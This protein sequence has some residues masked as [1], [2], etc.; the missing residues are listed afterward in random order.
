M[1]SEPMPEPVSREDHVRR[2]LSQ[3]I[4]RLGGLLGHVILNLEGQAIFDLIEEVRGATKQLREHPSLDSARAL[5]DR[6]KRLPLTTLRKLNRAFSIYFD[7]INLAEQQARLRSLRL[8]SLVA[9]APPS[10]GIESALRQLQEEKVGP[11]EL[12]R[13]LQQLRIVPV[14]TAHPSEARRR[15]ILEKLDTISADLARLDTEEL[16]ARDRLDI[17]DHLQAEIETLWLTNLVRT[18]RPSVLDEVRHGTAIIGPLMQV[19]PRLYKSLARSLGEVYPGLPRPPAILDF[20]SWIGGDRDG[21]PFVTADCTLE[22]V[23]ILQTRIIDSYLPR[24]EELTRI[25]SLANNLTT[26]GPAFQRVLDRCQ[27]LVPEALE[28]MQHEPYRAVCRAMAAR[29]QATREWVRQLRLYWSAD[30]REPPAIVYRARAEFLHDLRAMQEDLRLAGVRRTANGELEDLI[31]LVEVFGLHMFSL[32][33]RQHAARHTQAVDEILRAAEVCP[34]YHSLTPEARFALLARELESPRP[35]VPTHLSFSP[36]SCEVIQTFRTVSALLEQQ[37]GESIENYVISGATEPSDVLEVLLLAKE[38]RLFRPAEAISRIHVVPL[39]EALEPLRS[40]PQIIGQLLDLPVY[41]RHLELRG[42]LQEVMIGYS[43]SNKESGFLQS[44]WALYCAQRELAE[45]QRRSGVAIRIFHGRGGAIG[46]GGGPANRA[47]LAQPSGLADGCMRFTE[48]GEVIADRYGCPGIAERHLEQILN[49]VLRNSSAIETPPPLPE[50]EQLVGTL[51]ELARQHYRTLVYETPEFLTYFEQ[52]TPISEIGKL[53]IASRPAKRGNNRTAGIDE[54]RAIPW[55]FS[56]MQSRHTLP[57]WYGLGSA[58]RQHL[59]ETPSARATLRE[60]YARWP[61][62]RTLI[63]NAQMILAKADL[64]IARL[65]ADLVSSP[66]VGNQIH[67][68]IADEYATTVQAVLEMTGQRELLDTMP[69]LQRSI[70]QRNPYVD[71]LSFVQLVLLEQ[72]RNGAEPQ[73]EYLTGVL[74]SI[75]GIASGLKNTG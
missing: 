37:C 31:R 28:R 44:N 9:E 62:W 4:R 13:L 22:A 18:E 33:I 43:D 58:I 17:E 40:A 3:D 39:F 50:W 72:L 21:N 2:A 54:L 49:A 1:S 51:A 38:A 24:L 34:N 46:R 59:Q 27:E 63:D 16:S 57:G 48:Q 8:H 68:R 26:Q 70:Q 47:I 7:L 25:L 61:F 45:V 75:S 65:Y 15:S 5:R 67:G 32:D 73:D 60:M 29:L 71:P 41:R 14:F 55:V 10:D 66:E 56:W 64:T 23:R 36:P 35:L 69:V 52:A 11:A 74:E 42:G 12:S 30:P 6:L 20:G 53:K 19:V